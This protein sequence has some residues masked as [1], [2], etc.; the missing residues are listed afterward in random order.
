[1][2]EVPFIKAQFD[3][4]AWFVARKDITLGVDCSDVSH[5]RFVS[6]LLR[7]MAWSLTMDSEHIWAASPSTTRGQPTQLSSDAKG[8]RLA[9]AVQ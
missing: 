7:E 4:V 6:L 2:N 1:L 3:I 8:E 9:Y 5:K